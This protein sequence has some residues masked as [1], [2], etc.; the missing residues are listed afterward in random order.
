MP[1]ERRRKAVLGCGADPKKVPH[2]RTVVG[3]TCITCY[4]AM[5]LSMETRGRTLDTTKR[6]TD[7]DD[8]IFMLLQHRLVSETVYLRLR[9][10]VTAWHNRCM[11]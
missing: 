4:A 3:I 9:K 1:K 11:K 5:V 8:A 6:A 10:R 2:T 7:M